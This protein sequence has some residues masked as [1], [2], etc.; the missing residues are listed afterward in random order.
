MSTNQSQQPNKNKSKNSR[1]RHRQR[2]S[3]NKGNKQQH[4]KNRPKMKSNQS[5][6]KKVLEF[7]YKLPEVCFVSYYPTFQ[8]AREDQE[9]LAQ[10]KA[11]CDQLNIIIEEEAS[12]SAEQ[13]EDDPELIKYGKVFAGAAWTMIHERREEE[14][15]Y[16]NRPPKETAKP[17]ESTSEDDA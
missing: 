15:F 8:S 4:N 13:L 3:Q 16:K 9:K 11:E 5:S 1:R 7:S 17:E 12:V 6:A 14:G 2:P 10:L